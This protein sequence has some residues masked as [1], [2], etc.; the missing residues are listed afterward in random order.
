MPRRST[1]L[2]A[3]SALLAILAI[4]TPAH[5]ALPLRLTASDAS[6]GKN[7][8]RSVAVSGD[9]IIVGAT[10]LSDTTPET[11]AAYIYRWTG[12]TWGEEAKL[13]A[14]DAAS[15]DHFGIAVDIQGNL[16]IV[17]ARGNDDNAF[18]S[19]SAYI[20]RHGLGQAS[21]SMLIPL[22]SVLLAAAG[23]V[24]TLVLPTYSETSPEHGHSRPY[25]LPTTCS[26]RHT[27]ARRSL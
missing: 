12:T 3:F 20:F 7:F 8:G 25:S 24:A 17:G 26:P 4:A 13:L 9:T 10:P 15:A 2:T 22:S 27:S 6:A 16:A 5:A 21:P 23:V 14:S 19:G 11:G 1:P 18:D